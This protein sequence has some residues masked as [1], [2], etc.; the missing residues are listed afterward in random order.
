M[1]SL[2]KD[3]MVHG[4]YGRILMNKMPRA[5]KRKLD[6]QPDKRRR[7]EGKKQ[8]TINNNVTIQENPSVPMEPD[9]PVLGV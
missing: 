8:T 2:R 1:N 3:A 6:R 9:R 4:G 5:M 7:A